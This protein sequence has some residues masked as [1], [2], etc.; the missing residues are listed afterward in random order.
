MALKRREIRRVEKL[1]F[2][3]IGYVFFFITFGEKLI[4]IT[5]NI[6]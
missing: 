6:I 4:K 1:P 2:E 5:S 3:T